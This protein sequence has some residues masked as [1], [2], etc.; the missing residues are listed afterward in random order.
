[1][2][3]FK[4]FFCHIIVLAYTQFC[5]RSQ[6]PRERVSAFQVL[7]KTYD[8]LWEGEKEIPRQ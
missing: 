1:M 2:V 3:H 6:K 7:L 4:Y 8:N 5:V